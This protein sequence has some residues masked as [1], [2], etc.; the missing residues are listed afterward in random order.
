[1]LAPRAHKATGESVDCRDQEAAR[2]QM[3]KMV[4]WGQRVNEDPVGPK[5]TRGY[6][7][8]LARRGHRATKGRKVPKVRKEIRAIRVTR[9][10]AVSRE[11]RAIQAPWVHRVRKASVEFRGRRALMGLSVSAEK[12]ESRASGVPSA[13]LVRSEKREWKACVASREP[14]VTRV[15][16]AK[17]ETGGPRG[18]AST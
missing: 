3:A 8:L 18:R 2:D 6:R 5:A 1:M 4:P 7:E 17:K 12:Q 15:R 9:D 16:G 11:T 13:S 10:R 14:W